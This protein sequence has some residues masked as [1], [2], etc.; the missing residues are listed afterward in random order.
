MTSWE[1][2]QEARRE[3]EAFTRDVRAGKIVYSAEAARQLATNYNPLIASLRQRQITI[4]SEFTRT[5]FGAFTSCLQLQAGFQQHARDFWKCLSEHIE[6][7]FRL[8]EAFLRAGKQFA[9][10]DTAL[11][12]AI[13]QTKIPVP[14][15]RS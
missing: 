13:Q 7:A 4:Q 12:L 5:G 15:G 9:D 8:Q 6:V 11:A 3:Q 1:K 10:A 14:K 2:L